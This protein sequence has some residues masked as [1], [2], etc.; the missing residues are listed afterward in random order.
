MASSA[1]Q[2]V[3]SQAD[4]MSKAMANARARGEKL[5]RIHAS[6]AIAGA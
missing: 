4:D 5:K 6:D 3:G 2:A 1:V